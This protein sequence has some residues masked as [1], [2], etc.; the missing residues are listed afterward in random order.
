MVI[1]NAP[2]EAQDFFDGLV[3]TTS[4]CL[5]GST[6]LLNVTMDEIPCGMEP[7]NFSA[8]FPACNLSCGCD[9]CTTVECIYRDNNRSDLELLC[10]QGFTN[11]TKRTCA[12]GLLNNFQVLTYMYP[13][14]STKMIV[15]ATYRIQFC[16]S[17]DCA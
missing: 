15:W 2:G 12:Y 17:F 16:Y 3:N 5:N 1:R 10:S 9:Y 8:N 13:S 7:Y 11:L 4:Q 6:V 14:I